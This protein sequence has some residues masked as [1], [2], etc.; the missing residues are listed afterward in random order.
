MN[1]K[2]RWWGF[3]K[4]IDRNE[5]AYENVSHIAWNIP[6]PNLE[7]DE[8]MVANEFVQKVLEDKITSSREI[9]NSQELTL[10]Y[11]ND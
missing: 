10:V 7:H 1:G 11:K 3:T 6:I 4:V 5:N 9:I 8:Y 2:N